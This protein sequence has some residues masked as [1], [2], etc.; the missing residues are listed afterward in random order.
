MPIVR[1]LKEGDEASFRACVEECRQDNPPHE[2]VDRP[3]PHNLCAAICLDSI[4]AAA[5]PSNWFAAPGF[6]FEPETPYD[7]TNGTVS[8]GHVGA[9]LDEPLL[10]ELWQR[11]FDGGAGGSTWPAPLDVS[12]APVRP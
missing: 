1:K 10:V 9:A 2:A 4:A 11:S 8:Y 6:L 7:P 3:A 5:V 12:D